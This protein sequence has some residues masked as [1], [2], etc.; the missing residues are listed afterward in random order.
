MLYQLDFIL[1]EDSSFL[2][3][4][5]IL[6]NTQSHE[7][8]IYWW[9]NTAVDETDATR[10]LAPVEQAFV[11]DYNQILSKRSVPMYEGVDCSYCLLYTSR[12]V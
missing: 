10:V 9:S 6:K 11:N 7:T 8:P 1:P 12:C 3:V 4:R 5:V 2:F